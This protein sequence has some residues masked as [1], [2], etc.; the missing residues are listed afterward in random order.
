[1]SEWTIVAVLK[2]AEVM[3]LRGFESHPLRHLGSFPSISGMAFFDILSGFIP[4]LTA[5]VRSDRI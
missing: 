3:S 1:V 2:T 5:I 4:E